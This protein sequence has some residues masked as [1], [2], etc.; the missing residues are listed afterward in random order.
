MERILNVPGMFQRIDEV[1]FGDYESADHGP[2]KMDDVPWLYHRLDTML[3]RQTWHEMTDDR[4]YIPSQAEIDR[5]YTGI[6]P[7]EG[8]GNPALY[9][10]ASGGYTEQYWKRIS[11]IRRHVDNYN[12]TYPF[13]WQQEGDDSFFYCNYNSSMWEESEDADA[14]LSEI[15]IERQSAAP[16]DEERDII[17]E[18]PNES[19]E[20]RDPRQRK[21]TILQT[22]SHSSFVISRAVS[23]TPN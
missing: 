18:A 4:D 5:E 15:L 1:W 7:Y 6:P 22:I 16:S 3:F 19:P 20:T 21:Q 14:M 13:S 23:M 2:D 17:I 8:I 10:S 11:R 9:E 12:Y